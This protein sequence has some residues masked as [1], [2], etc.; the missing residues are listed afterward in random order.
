[1][2][3]WRVPA[4]APGREPAGFRPVH[5]LGSKL[6]LLGAISSALDDVDP[7]RGRTVDL[8]AGSGVVAAHLARGR[9]VVAVDVQEYSRVLAS[10]LLA[11]AR[12]PDALVD[13]LLGEARGRADALAAGA[14]RPLVDHERACVQAMV[15]G[16]P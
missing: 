5:Y 3:L 15:D 8:F 2:A 16:E 10:S 4:P 13:R 7:R 9:D 14:F 12:V 6:R 11:P 1:M